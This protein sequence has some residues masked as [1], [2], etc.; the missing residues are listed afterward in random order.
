[1]LEQVGIECLN[2]LLEAW[3]LLL[4]SYVFDIL[5]TVQVL[6]TSEDDAV[7]RGQFNSSLKI[8][9]IEQLL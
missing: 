7:Y 5:Y 1:M 8:P 2:C 6:D 3:G 9:P 4:A